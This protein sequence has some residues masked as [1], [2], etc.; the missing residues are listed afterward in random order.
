[1]TPK[2]PTMT[3]DDRTRHL[4]SPYAAPPCRVGDRLVCERYGESIVAEMSGGPIPWPV[5]RAPGRPRLILC[6]D[7]AHAWSP[8]P[9]SL[10]TALARGIRM[11]PG[12]V[13]FRARVGGKGRRGRTE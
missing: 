11:A 8:M 13:S 9:P 4:F 10:V 12:L 2:G 5:C 3:G 6:G 1:M 7:L